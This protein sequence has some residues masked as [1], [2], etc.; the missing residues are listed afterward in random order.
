MWSSW[1]WSNICSVTCKARTNS[2]GFYIHP[3][4]T[5]WS[6]NLF[7]SQNFFISYDFQ[8]SFRLNRESFEHL[9]RLLQLSIEK[10]ITRFRSLVP[11][12]H[13]LTIFLY[14][15]AHEI[16]YR[17]ISNQFAVGRMTVSNIIGDVSKAICTVLGKR[18]I[19]FPT[20]D[21]AL[22]TMEAFRRLKGHIPGVVLRLDG[23]HIP[24]RRPCDSGEVYYNRKSFYRFNIQ[25]IPRSCCYLGA[26]DHKRRFRDL[27]VGWPGSVHDFRVLTNSHLYKNI[28]TLLSD[29]PSTRITTLRDDGTSQTELVPP[30]VL[31]NS[32]YSNET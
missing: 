28:E 18:Y 6:E 31:C 23:C 16:P 26:L 4:S 20:R 3:R 12:R 2:Q 22:R 17:V 27:V 8:A 10:A 11:S 9:H 1:F 15:V 14:H 29:L 13:R 32:R 5:Y 19:Q 21:E 24:I 30:F 7:D 25:C